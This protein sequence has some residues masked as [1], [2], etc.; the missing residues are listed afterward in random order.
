MAWSRVRPFVL[1]LLVVGLVGVLYSRGFVLGLGGKQAELR[2]SYRTEEAWVVTEVV[3]HVTELSAAA[4]APGRELTSPVASAPDHRYELGGVQVDL[5]AAVWSPDAF[6][7]LARALVGEPDPARPPLDVHR[8]LV[9]LRAQQLVRQAAD[10]DI[11]LRAHPRDAAGHEAAALVIAA[12]ALREDAWRFTDVR[13]ELNRLTARLAFANALRGGQPPSGDGRLAEIVLL[14]LANHQRQAVAALDEASRAGRGAEWSA[15][16]RAL[17]LRVDQDWRAI[18]VP[19]TATRLEQLEY[20]RSRRVTMPGRLGAQEL[21]ALGAAVD[22]DTDWQRIVVSRGQSVSDSWL[23]SVKS[24]D[25]ELAE[26]RAVLTG[27]GGQVGSEAEVIHAVSSVSSA[28]GG[29]EVLPWEAWAAQFQRHLANGISQIDRHYR[30]RIGDAA[31]ADRAKRAIDARLLAMPLLPLAGISR[32]TGPNGGLVDAERLD[33]A[34]TLAAASPERVPAYLWEFLATAT[35]YEPLGREMPDARAWFGTPAART[36][37]NAADRSASDPAVGRTALDALLAEAPHDYDLAARVLSLTHGGRATPAVLRAAFGARLDY[38]LRAMHLAIDASTDDDERLALQERACVVS[39]TECADLGDLMVWRGRPDAAAR[40]FERAFADPS[41]E[42]VGMA[43]RSRWLVRH[44]ERSGASDRAEALADRV[45]DTGALVG[46]ESKAWLTERRGDFDTAEALHRRI[47]ER[48]ELPGGLYGFYHRMV[49]DRRRSDYEPRLRELESA[50]L[51]DGRVDAAT[52]LSA[53]PGAGVVITKDS[54][55]SRR[56][57]IQVGDIIVGVQGGRV[58][59]LAEYRALNAVPD[60]ER[61]DLTIWRGRIF[62]AEFEATARLM[63]VEFRNH[64]LKGWVDET[65]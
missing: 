51:P 33:D 13:V 45:A 4:G 23:F 42:A 55:F 61:M 15:G 50:L 47:A 46:L 5:S 29:A 57:N 28:S 36:P 32:T 63:G 11:H 44:Y 14:T 18:D 16:V 7:P 60:H 2:T 20:F 59:N 6:A 64:P 25:R 40:A 34:I 39:P 62:R 12:F 56:H 24:L 37:Y 31:A 41:F 9:D 58:R 19:Q 3:R 52:S 38:D 48:Y 1:A 53:P 49:H 26:A 21:E 10:V 17:R 22:A 30:H 65:H 27:R 43:N 54:P 8:T 35:R